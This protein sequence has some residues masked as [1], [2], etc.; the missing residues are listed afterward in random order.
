LLNGNHPV[1][2]K[3]TRSRAALAANDDPIDVGEIKGAE[4]FKQRLDGKE[5]HGG[6]G[7]AESV[8]ARKPMLAVFHGDAPPD[9]RGACRFSEASG[10][11]FFHTLGALGED[12]VGVPIRQAHDGGDMGD[13]VLRNI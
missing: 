10:E 1:Y 5:F 6:T 3:G 12:L 7:A 13:V 4:V 8:D 9:V 2:F 11:E